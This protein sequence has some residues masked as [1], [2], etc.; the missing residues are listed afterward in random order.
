MLKL[1]VSEQLGMV[2][3]L[4]SRVDCLVFLVLPPVLVLRN[5]QVI[6]SV[7][8]PVPSYLDSTRA[9]YSPNNDVH[10]LNFDTPGM[11]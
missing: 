8:E 3:G 10:P 7:Y 9:S 1:Q 2:L 11:S 5:P 4:R 6:T